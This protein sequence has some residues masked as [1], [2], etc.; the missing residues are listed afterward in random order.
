MRVRERGKCLYVCVCGE[1]ERE[2]GG[3]CERGERGKEGVGDG[4]KE[5]ERK[6]EG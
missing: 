4:E 1:R 3:E 2:T 6:K 5:E